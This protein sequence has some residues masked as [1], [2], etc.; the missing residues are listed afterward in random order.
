MRS[1]RVGPV[2]LIALGILAC[3]SAACGDTEGVTDA[4]NSTVTPSPSGAPV[5]PADE[6][7]TGPAT[8]VTP[9]PWDCTGTPPTGWVDQ[10]PNSDLCVIVPAPACPGVTINNRSYCGP[11]AG[12]YHFG[13]GPENGY[14]CKTW[15]V[16]GD[17]TVTWQTDRDGV[18]SIVQWKVLDA[19]SAVFADLHR[20]FYEDVSKQP[21]LTPGAAPAEPFG[22]TA[23]PSYPAGYGPP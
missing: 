16:L 19:D 8:W 21:T 14:P 4:T 18:T 17:S 7:N 12:Q 2:V 13:C 6:I 22:E 9:P 10:F 15:V 23:P 3:L 20:A 5:P 11:L 1:L